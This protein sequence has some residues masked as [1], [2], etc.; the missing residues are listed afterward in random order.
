M[1]TALAGAVVCVS[2]LWIAI[3]ATDTRVLISERL[4][5]PGEHYVTEDYGDLGGREGSSLVCQY[6]NGR[7]VLTHVFWYASNNIFGR[8]SCR[9]LAPFGE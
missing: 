2:L 9:F 5:R 8:D 7:R 6:F 1:G 4:V 3:L